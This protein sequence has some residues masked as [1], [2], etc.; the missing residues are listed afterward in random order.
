MDKLK[1][2]EDGT[3]E[4]PEG[5]LFLPN[6]D[7]RLPDGKVL[8]PGGRGHVLFPDGTVQR[9]DGSTYQYEPNPPPSLEAVQADAGDRTAALSVMG[10]FAH[11]YRDS[12][13]E[14]VRFVAECLGD[15]L[16]NSKV[17]DVM[18]QGAKLLDIGELLRKAFKQGGKIDCG[19]DQT[20]CILGLAALC[21]LS[22]EVKTSKKRNEKIRAVLRA[23][24]LDEVEERNDTGTRTR[25]KGTDVQ[26]NKAISHALSRNK[27]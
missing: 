19:R 2:W 17:P 21:E 7:V 4:L 14:D 24:G 16:E 3:I 8:F 23:Y 10:S 9:L 25:R 26:L 20:K 6:G 12:D 22:P 27:K 1:K 11:R 15:F 13:D 5:S 18:L